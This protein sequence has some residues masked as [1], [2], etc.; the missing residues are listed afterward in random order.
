MRP[1]E[2]ASDWDVNPDPAGAWYESENGADW[3]REF[4]AGLLAQ[5][6]N[7]ALELGETLDDE[8]LEG[9][10]KESDTIKELITALLR[11]RPAEARIAALKAEAEAEACR[12]AT[13]RHPVAYRNW[14]H[15]QEAV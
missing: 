13:I 5:R 2:A 10:I 3:H 6:D 15:E 12:W 9:F 14:L 1:Q 4:V 7:K 8:W 11:N